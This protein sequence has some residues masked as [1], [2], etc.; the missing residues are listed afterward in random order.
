MN[1]ADEVVPVAKVN[2]TSIVFVVA[3]PV[4]TVTAVAVAKVVAYQ[5][6]RKSPAFDLPPVVGLTLIVT[7]K[8]MCP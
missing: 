7:G 1:E 2:W 3:V 4:S 8:R 5:Y 6:P